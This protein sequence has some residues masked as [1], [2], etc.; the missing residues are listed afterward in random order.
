LSWERYADLSHEE[1]ITSQVC[2][3]HHPKYQHWWKVHIKSVEEHEKEARAKEDLNLFV[4]AWEGE[5]KGAVVHQC[6]IL[7][8]ISEF[9]QV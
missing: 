5:H 9:G 1:K 8:R 3:E 2:R 6:Q 4:W 7:D